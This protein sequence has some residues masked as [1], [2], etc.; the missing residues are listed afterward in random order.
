MFQSTADS[1]RRPTPSRRR[2][3][4]WIAPSLKEGVTGKVGPAS[5]GVKR[6]AP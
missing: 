4:G 5:P 6:E 1:I 3:D 2:G